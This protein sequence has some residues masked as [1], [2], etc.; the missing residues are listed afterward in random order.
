MWEIEGTDEFVAWFEALDRE[1][2]VRVAEMIPVAGDLYR[3]HLDEL[4]EEGLIR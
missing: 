4:R 2:K 1:D 3:S